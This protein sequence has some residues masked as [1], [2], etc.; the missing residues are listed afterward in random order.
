MGGEPADI[1][2]FAGVPSSVGR[3]SASGQP[4]AATRVQTVNKRSFAHAD[5]AS[6]IHY[7]IVGAVLLAL[8]SRGALR[9]ERRGNRRAAI[10]CTAAAA[11]GGE[12]GVATAEEGFPCR[13]AEAACPRTQPVLAPTARSRH[14]AHGE[15]GI[16]SPSTL[17]PGGTIAELSHVSEHAATPPSALGGLPTSARAP[18]GAWLGA[19]GGAKFLGATRQAAHRARGR[20]TGAT[21]RAAAAREQQ[22]R[23]RLGSKLQR[24]V[25]EPRVEAFDPSRLRTAIQVGQQSARNQRLAKGRECKTLATGGGVGN[26]L[27]S[28]MN[29]SI[30]LVDYGQRLNSPEISVKTDD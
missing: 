10:V 8:A 11:P 19:H 26:A 21:A 24:P 2:A 22:Q 5:T 29:R 7:G 3:A 13:V 17:Q 25:I 9:R 6:A 30:R 12:A 16:G 15:R 23:R 20:R 18:H 27:C 28:S 14:G 1:H 4:P